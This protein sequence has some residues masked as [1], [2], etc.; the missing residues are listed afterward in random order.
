MVTPFDE[1]GSV[2][3]QKAW[4]LAR[5]LAEHGTDTLVVAGTTGESP[6]LDDSEKLALF[7]TVID[8]VSG[9]KTK[10]VAGTGTYDTA[11]SVVM[12]EKAADLGA[13]G[14]LAVTPYYNK[15]SQ[16]GLIAHFTAMAEVG[17]PVMLYNIPG[18]TSRLIDIDTL[19]RLAEH[20]NIVAMKDA[21]GD[22]DFTS[23]TINLAP[24]FPVYS[25]DDSRTLPMMAVGAVGVVSVISH[26]AGPAVRAMV[27]AAAAGDYTEA[28][29]LHHQLLPLQQAC[30]SE[31][32]PAP[33]KGA[34]SKVWEPVG[35]VRLPLVDAS[36]ETLIAVEKA[37]GAIPN[38]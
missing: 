23:T 10:V 26:L 14:V 8:A 29:R 5:H 16:D 32:S 38:P 24:G 36:E 3:H 35:H 25:G 30:F 17:A 19:L 4:D 12:T 6:T 34:L 7:K 33:V 18:R 1:A 31:P 11:H 27:K 28:R 2:D 22:I 13:D 37:L 20:P 21:V 15:P 9:K